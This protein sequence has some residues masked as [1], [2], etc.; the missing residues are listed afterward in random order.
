ML[1]LIISITFKLFLLHTCYTCLSSHNVYSLLL[2]ILHFYKTE[3]K[4]Q[5][6]LVFYDK[7]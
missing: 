7:I 4:K 1:N 3:G 2:I 6:K 5:N